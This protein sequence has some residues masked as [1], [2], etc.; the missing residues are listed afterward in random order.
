MRTASQ[1][2]LGNIYIYTRVD[3]RAFSPAFP[4]PRVTALP[5][6]STLMPTQA[7]MLLHS[8]SPSA[9]VGAVP[10]DT[11]LR[12]YELISMPGNDQY[13]LQRAMTSSEERASA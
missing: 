2:P 7:G 10:N 8:F 4:V 3:R 6:T 11:T 13:G 5:F 9:T 12:P 1:C